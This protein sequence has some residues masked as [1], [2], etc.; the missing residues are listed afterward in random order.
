MKSLVRF[1]VVARVYGLQRSVI[2]IDTSNNTQ[3]R[4][5]DCQFA[6]AYAALRNAQEGTAR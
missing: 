3:T 1:I 4:C 6:E 5:F 2:V